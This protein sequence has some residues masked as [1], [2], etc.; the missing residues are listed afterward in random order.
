MSC[1][2]VHVASTPSV[3]SRIDYRTTHTRLSI[4]M[5]LHCVFMQWFS[6]HLNLGN[7]VMHSAQHVATFRVLCKSAGIGVTT[8]FST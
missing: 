4:D 3:A 7:Q 5:K 6:L 1:L 2:C 8:I